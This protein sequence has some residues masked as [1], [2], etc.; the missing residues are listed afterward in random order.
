MIRCRIKLN[1]QLLCLNFP[2]SGNMRD[3]SVQ[4]KK[5]PVVRKVA[6]G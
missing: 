5:C 2:R 1:S 3:N 6:E 4:S